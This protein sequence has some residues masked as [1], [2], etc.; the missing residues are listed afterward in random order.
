[1]SKVTEFIAITEDGQHFIGIPDNL[2]DGL[3]DLVKEYPDGIPITLGNG[4]IIYALALLI[5][6]PALKEKRPMILFN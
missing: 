6:T 1:M 5:A 3:K 4:E 2:I